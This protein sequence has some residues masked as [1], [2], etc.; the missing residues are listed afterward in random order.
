[1]KGNNENNLFCKWWKRSEVVSPAS[2]NS[3]TLEYVQ[4]NGKRKE[5][6]YDGSHCEKDWC[7]GEGVEV[8]KKT[9]ENGGKK[10]IQQKRIEKRKSLVTLFTRKTE[11]KDKGKMAIAV[12]VYPSFMTLRLEKSDVAIQSNG[13]CVKTNL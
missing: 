9:M 6:F 12:P 11:M 1:M 2:G 7:G 4:E 5:I 3:Q 8:R 13:N 10:S